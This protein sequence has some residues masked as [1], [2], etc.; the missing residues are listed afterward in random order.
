[1]AKTTT[2]KVLADR[3]AGSIPKSLQKKQTRVNWDLPDNAEY[4]ERCA[5]S[6][7]T[8]TDLCEPDES[9]ASFTRNVGINRHVLL[10]YMA[11]IEGGEDV[12][13]K[14]GRKTYLAE[15]VMRHICEGCWLL[16][17]RLL[18]VYCLL[19]CCLLIV[20]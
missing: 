7:Q 15:D 20:C 12:G 3:I 18:F 14:R 17:A 9:F 5:K 1:M 10:R 6:W 16:F 19:G 2:G 11:R 4:R 8:K 13:K